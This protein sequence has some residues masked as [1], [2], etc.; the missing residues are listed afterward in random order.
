MAEAGGVSQLGWTVLQRDSVLKLR[1]DKLARVRFEGVDER[2]RP[3]MSALVAQPHGGSERQT[4][5]IDEHGSPVT[6][7]GAVE[8]LDFELLFGPK[9]GRVV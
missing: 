3:V 8:K 6:P 4:W 5:A 1:R 9:P 7:D 2:R